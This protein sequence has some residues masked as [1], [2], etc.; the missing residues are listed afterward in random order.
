[1]NKRKS[2]H[3][4]NQEFTIPTPMVSH[5]QQCGIGAPQGFVLTP[6][7]ND[8]TYTWWDAPVGGNIL[9]S[10]KSSKFLQPISSTTQLY[11]SANN[12]LTEETPRSEAIILT[13]YPP[14]GITI[15]NSTSIC[16]GAYTQLTFTQESGSYV[17]DTFLWSSGGETGSGME[18]DSTEASPIIIPTIPGTYTYTL[19][20]SKANVYEVSGNLYPCA[21]KV[22]ITMN[23][24]ASPTVT[25]ADILSVC[26]FQN[27][28]LSATSM[29][30][31]D[32]FEWRNLENNATFQGAQQTLTFAQGGTK[33]FSLTVT[34][35]SGCSVVVPVFFTVNDAPPAPSGNNGQDQC[36]T[37]FTDASVSSNNGIDP[38][39]PPFFNW[40]LVPTGGT[41][42][43]SG[44]STTFE[45]E[46]SSTTTFYVSEVSLKGCEGPRVAITTTV[47]EPDLVTVTSTAATVYLGASFNISSSY[48]PD[49]NSF[50]T[51]DLTATGGDV[52]GVIGVVSLTP[53]A[54][55]SDAYSVTPTAAGTYT[56]TISANDPDKGCKSRAT[57]DIVIV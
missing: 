9:Q 10:G 24:L 54:T 38:Q 18:S 16:V 11:V 15:N 56:Y 28:E 52:S 37:A 26:T 45:K 42:V 8:I 19:L 22:E 33:E 51:F 35:T 21:T 20:A 47:T 30:I 17:Y 13:V 7:I 27:V 50:A 3:N 34:S 2:F 55:G 39:S 46:I 53:N 44:T 31:D 29:D 23:V 41:T 49:F 4:H 57:I 12:G 1:M 32:T 5:S 6:G 40:Y 25:V 48:T 14:L 36:G 43:Q